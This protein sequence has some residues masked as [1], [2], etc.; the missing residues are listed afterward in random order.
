EW[1]QVQGDKQPQVL[2]YER[3]EV[4]LAITVPRSSSS[5]AGESSV[6]IGARPIRSG[7]ASG[8]ATAQWNVLPFEDIALSMS[9]A[10]SGGLRQARH[11][12]P[13]HHRGHLSTQH[14]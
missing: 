4:T 14:G 11:H 5:K 12:T 3:A 13:L 8:S 7:D 9:P 2:A 6:T 1:V 10:R